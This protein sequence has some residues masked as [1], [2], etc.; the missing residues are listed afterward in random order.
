MYLI[1]NSQHSYYTMRSTFMWSTKNEAA[2]VFPVDKPK[3]FMIRSLFRKGTGQHWSFSKFMCAYDTTI[4]I[5][6]WYFQIFVFIKIASL[7]FLINFFVYFIIGIYT[8]LSVYI[9]QFS[10]RFAW[11]KGFPCFKTS[12]YI[13]YVVLEWAP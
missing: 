3:V 6:N 8:F 7:G 13:K 2:L 10:V 5:H 11:K 9:L 1:E 12:R 4:I